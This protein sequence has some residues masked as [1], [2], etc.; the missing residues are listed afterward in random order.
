[1]ESNIDYVVVE[2]H[3]DLPEEV[4]WKAITEHEQM[5]QW[6]FNNIPDFK[7]EEGF[8]TE[9]N[10]R[11]EERE[12]LHQWKILE[13]IPGKRIVYDW[14]YKQ[15]PGI[16]RVEFELINVRNGT[17]LRVSTYGLHTFPQNIPE[18]SRDSCRTGWNY[19]IKDRLRIYLESKN[20]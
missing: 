6:F 14:Q 16:G 12:F 10:V 3:F 4:I 19:F 7:A 18:F 2:H 9:F 8:Y 13:V 1:M 20:N 17:N 11:S 15:Y 5:I